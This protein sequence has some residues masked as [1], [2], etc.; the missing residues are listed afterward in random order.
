MVEKMVVELALEWVVWQVL[1]T[2]WGS[3]QDYLG[4]GDIL[5]V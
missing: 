5:L 4:G 3:S 1:E 2:A